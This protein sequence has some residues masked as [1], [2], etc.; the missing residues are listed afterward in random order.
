MSL[1]LPWLSNVSLIL[2]GA[3]TVCIS[4][5]VRISSIETANAGRPC[6]AA[7]AGFDVSSAPIFSGKGAETSQRGSDDGLSVISTGRVDVP[8]LDGDSSSL[9][10]LI[11]AIKSLVAATTTWCL[12][13][14]FD[15]CCAAC[16]T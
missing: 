2:P 1:L 12:K 9:G 11:D 7:A 16:E 15:L 10:Y 14:A 5:L 4:G 6:M 13:G 3:K 8:L